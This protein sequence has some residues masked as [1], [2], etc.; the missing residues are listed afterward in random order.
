MTTLFPR[1]KSDGPYIAIRNKMFTELCEAI[2]WYS[3]VSEHTGLVRNLSE[4]EAYQQMIVDFT[5]ALVRI[6]R[7]NEKWWSENR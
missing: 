5:I 7:F 3:A 2:N 6:S 1:F 4:P